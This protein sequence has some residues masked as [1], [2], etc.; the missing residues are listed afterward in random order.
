MGGSGGGGGNGEQEVKQAGGQRASNG[1]RSRGQIGA[2]GVGRMR[3]C[4]AR[5]MLGG[6]RQRRARS[7]HL[8]SG[9]I[10]DRKR[11]RH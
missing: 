10:A 3:Q 5:I 4:S 7:S 1:D 8:G 11:A 2:A 9:L 6:R